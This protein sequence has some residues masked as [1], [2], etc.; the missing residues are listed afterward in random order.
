M[1]PW[2]IYAHDNDKTLSENLH[3]TCDCI[4]GLIVALE[5]LIVALDI[6]RY[7]NISQ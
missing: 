2:H 6:D 3:K 1:V 7:I 4:K 5:S